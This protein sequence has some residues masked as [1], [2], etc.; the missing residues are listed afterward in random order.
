MGRSLLLIDNMS[1]FELYFLNSCQFVI[2]SSLAYI[3]FDVVEIGRMNYGSSCNIAFK[4]EMEMDT[5]GNKLFGGK[6]M[7][8]VLQ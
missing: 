5:F 3:I 8:T 4:N 2:S 7:N 6:S 1:T